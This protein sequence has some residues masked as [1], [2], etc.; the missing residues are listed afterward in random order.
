MLLTQCA[1]SA[2]QALGSKCSLVYAVLAVKLSPDSQLLLH[3]PNRE[4]NASQNRQ[5]AEHYS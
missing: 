4:A 1:D 2:W 3:L 5:V